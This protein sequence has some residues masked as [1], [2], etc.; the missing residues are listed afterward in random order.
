M[1][2]H[3]TVLAAVAAFLMP[4]QAAAQIKSYRAEVVREYPH[5]VTSYTQGLFFYEGQMYES[6]GV[7]GE[8]TFR[9]VDLETGKALRRLDFSDKYFVEGSVAFG[10]DLYILTWHN[11][12]AF[13]Y[14]MNTLEYKSTWTYPREG[15]GLTTDGNNLVASDGSS[16]LYFMDGEFNVQRK[17]TVRMQGRPMRLLNE[18]EYIDGKIWANVYTSDIILVINPADG[19]VEAT[20]DCSGLLPKKLRKPDTDVL[21]GIAYNADD[22]KVYL[23][24]KNWPRLYEVRIV[25]K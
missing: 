16:T 15:W 19:N 22:G 6:T 17:V 11:N 21:N 7:A 10:S 8:S 25:E 12:V 9:K 3:V 4:L 20:I 5:D 23:T 1:S 2:I 24:G 18:L 13:I 14:D